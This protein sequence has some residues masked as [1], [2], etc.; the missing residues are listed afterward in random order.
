MELRLHSPVGADPV[1][2]KWPMIIGRGSDKHDGALG[3]IETIKLVSDD[4]PDMKIPLENNILCN[5][6][7]KSYDSMKSL[8]DRFNKAIDSMVQMNKGTSLQKF[9]K[10][11][12]KNLL[13]HIIQQVYNVS[14]TDPDKLNQYEPFSPEVY[15]ETSFDLICQM[16]DLIN[17][18]E[19][20]I[21]IDLG[22]GVGQIVLQMAA[23]T[24]CKICWGVEKADVPS[25]YSKFMHLNFQKWMS[26][27]GKEC[28]QYQLV[29]GDFLSEE[30]REKITNATIVFVNNYAFGPQVDHMLKQRFADLKDG[31]RI[32]SSRSFCPLNFRMSERNLS[33]IGTIMHVSAMEPITGSVS[34]TCNPVK[35][36]LHVIDRTKLERYFTQNKPPVP[37]SRVNGDKQKL[38]TTI[39]V[40]NC[41]SDDTDSLFSTLNGD[42]V[43]GSAT[44][45]LTSDKTIT[46]TNGQCTWSDIG[47][48]NSEE[49]N[50]NNTDNHS[51]TTRKVMKRNTPR[52]SR[53]FKIAPTSYLNR[54]HSETTV[55]E[56]KT[57]EKIAKGKRVVSTNRK[58]KAKR[59]P[60][61]RNVKISA[62]LNLLHSETVLSTTPEVS[63]SIKEPPK[64]CVD[65]TLTSITGVGAGYAATHTEL[66]PP[67]G[68]IPYSLQLLLD[69]YKEG[70]MNMINMFKTQ[71]FREDV[72]AQIKAEREKKQNSNMKINQI[73]KQIDHL[74]KD[75]C[76]LLKTRMKELDIY[77]TNT[78]GDVLTAAKVIV[79][80][81]KDLQTKVA[82]IKNETNVLENQHWDYY[83]KRAAEVNAVGTPGHL[84]LHQTDNSSDQEINT[85]RL[86]MTELMANRKRKH[87]LSTNIEGVK[88][89]ID[90]LEKQN[91]TSKFNNSLV[92]QMCNNKKSRIRSQDWPEVPDIARIDE[93]NPEILAQKILETGRQIEAR[94][95]I[96]NGRQ[97]EL[98]TRYQRSNKIFNR[99]SSDTPLKVPFYDEHVK[100]LITN[101]LNEPSSKGP[102]YSVVSPAK[103]ALRRH[104]SQE[105][106][107][108][109]PPIQQQNVITRTIGDVLNNEIERCLEMDRHNRT[110]EIS[111]QSII[112]AVVP[113]SMHNRN[114]D[115][116]Q[117]I[118]QTLP[119]EKRS[120]MYIPLP[121]AE[122]KPYQE[123][124][125]S[126]DTPPPHL[127]TLKEEPVE[128][129][130]ASL[131]DRLLDNDGD[132]SNGDEGLS[133]KEEKTESDTQS[134]HRTLKRSSESPGPL[135][136][137]KMT[138]MSDRLPSEEDEK[139][140]D[141]I[142]ERF[143]SL[144]TFASLE[145]D[146]RRRNSSDAAA[147]NTSPD[148]GIGH[149]DPPPAL[150][151]PPSPSPPFSPAPLDGPYSPVPAPTVTAPNIPLRYQRHTNH[152]KKSFRDKYRSTGPKAK[153]WAAKWM[154]A[155]IQS[156]SN[157]F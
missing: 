121:K 80:R 90:N 45:G 66:P 153:T 113:L 65:H 31:A 128:G 139:W 94:K 89:E 88:T 77:P 19:D 125:F 98:S 141:R 116:T 111:N 1:V 28:G 105:K 132:D 44:N 123:S 138:P 92:N 149:G 84:L 91:T 3:I 96:E 49:E 13:R 114:N 127:T 71:K 112:N 29:K 34:W 26:W 58:Q 75:S 7:T 146:K 35:Y 117:A 87:A 73:K 82:K 63:M 9:S 151:P 140:N 42:S 18:T 83:C 126:D 22:S 27:Y 135:N 55:P 6:D 148:S 50:E 4:F 130:A 134:P 60:P 47:G 12:S 67:T 57:V 23:A 95:I 39:S 43:D 118:N 17:I 14:V 56:K 85:Q 16:I 37:K 74:I 32:V 152:K 81:H 119:S 72:E 115:T 62:S 137:K 101:A 144:V 78:T 97:V 129:L 46:N 8:C 147:A 36:Y 76:S 107:S 48:Q 145:L 41:S 133:F 30:H 11:A 102:D 10:K 143:D 104:L 131:H 106:I 155:E 61:K 59:K 25:S 103:V 99:N 86:L 69:D 68:D 53:S 110:L 122:L 51:R 21:F 33:D 150:Q 2:Y 136:A 157:F 64:G 40:N 79:L 142:R 100:D 70:F 109:S 24:Q 5:Y 54:S 93:K 120:F 156:T 38:T 124:L 20:D 108:P 15:G 52:R 154:D